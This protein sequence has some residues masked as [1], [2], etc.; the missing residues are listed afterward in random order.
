MLSLG[1]HWGIGAPCIACL[2]LVPSF[3]GAQEPSESEP[4]TTRP[5]EDLTPVHAG[6]ALF[7]GGFTVEGRYDRGR[8]AFGDGYGFYLVG[9][10]VLFPT[11]YL[12]VQYALALTGTFGETQADSGWSTG[13]V[14]IAA[15]V[16][17]RF[18]ASW[19][20]GGLLL[21]VGTRRWIDWDPL[22]MAEALVGFGH[23]R[24]TGAHFEL[25]GG[26]GLGG[27]VAGFRLGTMFTRHTP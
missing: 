13:S 27:Y 4:S 9:G 25:F 16:G 20:Y 21:R 24:R 23:R 1:L 17:P 18:Y 14:S 11:T 3:A 7:Q 8:D 26:G 2:V 22:V 10:L 6:G 5:T 12:T 19:F 15:S